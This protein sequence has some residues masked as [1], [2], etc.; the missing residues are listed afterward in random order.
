MEA[1]CYHHS[2]INRAHEDVDANLA[3]DC[4]GGDVGELPAIR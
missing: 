1:L 2:T 3:V 4:D